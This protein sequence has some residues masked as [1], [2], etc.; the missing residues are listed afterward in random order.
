MIFSQILDI[1]IKFCKRVFQTIS[2]WN[3]LKIF[4]FLRFRFNL[5][6][7]HGR[8]SSYIT[9][10]LLDFY[11]TSCTN[12]IFSIFTKLHLCFLQPNWIYPLSKTLTQC[13]I[14][15]QNRHNIAVNAIILQFFGGIQCQNVY[16]NAGPKRKSRMKR[17]TRFVQKVALYILAFLK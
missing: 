4:T 9:K 2:L 1:L 3:S 15:L 8:T 11:N 6:C 13:S 12:M 7:T 14:S 17:N 10:D 16:V 5:N